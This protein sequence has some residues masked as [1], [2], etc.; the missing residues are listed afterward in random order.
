MPSELQRVRDRRAT[1]PP[2][3]V[4]GRLNASLL[5]LA[6]ALIIAGVPLMFGRRWWASGVA[7]LAFGFLIRVFF[8]CSACGKRRGLTGGLSGP[9]P[10]CTPHGS[11]GLE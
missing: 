6:A 1:S 9:C 10:H 2:V 8:R 11:D 3:V 4:E 5:I 7:M